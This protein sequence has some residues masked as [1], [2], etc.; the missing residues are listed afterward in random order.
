[1]V[2]VLIL[3]RNIRV[4]L[5]QA[6]ER[7]GTLKIG[8]GMSVSKKTKWSGLT[9]D[10]SIEI[11]TP[12][13]MIDGNPKAA[14]DHFHRLQNLDTP[15]VEAYECMECMVRFEHSDHLLQHLDTHDTETIKPPISDELECQ[16]CPFKSS[17]PDNEEYLSRHV[18][19]NHFEAQ[20]PSSIL[21]SPPKSQIPES[22][23]LVTDYLPGHTKG[24]FKCNYCPRS[25]EQLYQRRIHQRYN[26]SHEFSELKRLIKCPTCKT[27]CKDA[28]QF[29]LHQ[30]LYCDVE[31]QCKNC[32]EKFK[33]ISQY[34]THMKIKHEVPHAPQTQEIYLPLAK[35]EEDCFT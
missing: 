11:P 20:L 30:S 28:A 23:D 13:R 12:K 14:F 31:F 1:M 32:S 15:S 2:I 6:E 9:K 33:R 19:L 22:P 10:N 21:P 35:P 7:L 4:G 17:G 8:Y 24:N 29:R 25:F 5:N 18:I 27:Y 26:H 16:L 3:K 34:T